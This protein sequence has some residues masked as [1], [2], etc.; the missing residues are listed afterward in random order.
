MPNRFAELRSPNTRSLPA[1][2]TRLR[3]RLPAEGADAV[4][5]LLDS[6]NVEDDEAD[7][8]AAAQPLRL[9][10]PVRPANR[11]VVR[12]AV[13][14]VA[15][16]PA[17]MPAAKPA[18]APA[19]KPAA[20][21]LA[22]PVESAPVQA[23]PA[24]AEPA[25]PL[26][27]PKSAEQAAIVQAF[28]AGDC[29]LVVNAVAG[30][31]KT[32]CILH[33]ALALRDSAPGERVLVLTYNARL[34]EE[35]RRKVRALGLSTEVHSF[36]AF[37][38]RFYSRDCHKDEGLLR[39]VDDDAA[40]LLRF[41]FNRI[42]VDE[43]QD[44]TPTFYRLVCKVMRDNQRSQP[45]PVMLLGDQHQNIFGFKYADARYLTLARDAFVG[46]VAPLP[47]RTL[48]LSTTFRLSGNMVAFANTNVMHRP[49]FN[50]P[51]AAGD[52]VFYY[53]G[54]AFAIARLLADK[55]IL[56]LSRRE[57]RPSDIFVL[58]P[59]IRAGKASTPTPY[60]VL[61]NLL[62][63]AGHPCFSSTSDDARLDE[64]VIR[65]KVVF[66]TFHSVKGL[67]RKVVVI[68]SFSKKY[69]DFFDKS[70]DYSRQRTCPNAL[71]VALTRATHALHLVGE[72]KEGDVLPFLTALK[73][74][75]YLQV[76]TVGVLQKLGAQT[77][78]GWSTASVTRLTRFLTEASITE[79][80]RFVRTQVVQE[81]LQRIS[82][83]L[84]VATPSDDVMLM[85]DVSELN[86]LAVPAFYESKSTGKMSSMQQHC[87]S[88]L[89]IGDPYH[90]TAKSKPKSM[91]D[92]LRLAAVYGFVTGG[93]VA[94]PAQIKDYDW[95]TPELSQALLGI[96]DAHL[97]GEKVAYEVAVLLN[98]E[99]LG[100]PTQVAKVSPMEV[101][102]RL[103]AVTSDF[104]WE[105]K[106]TGDI[107]VEHL[108]QLALYGWL[109]NVLPA[110]TGQPCAATHGSR[111]LRLLNFRTGEVREITS[112]P[113][114]L[115]QVARVLMEE[116]LRADPNLSDE[117]FLR[118]CQRHRKPYLRAA[119]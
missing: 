34:K 30:S 42:V 39:V 16:A 117:V 51:N 102:G 1:L 85:E 36:H 71:Y 33:A 61:E 2:L 54:D 3:T 69:F 76:L 91:A 6:L 24:A 83:P 27:Q 25:G 92:Y 60:N 62:V 17:A 78:S 26:L 98:G 113:A 35:T 14:P 104:I 45:C 5:V 114:E 59:S 95:L 32:T 108:L 119:E 23:A 43:A 81:P 86:G 13:R 37:G 11:P 19:A 70:A 68:F 46:I 49:H 40:P 80:M 88:E 53:R 112:S 96:I 105:L 58:S 55:L 63:E 111:R 20:K 15:P 47:W 94:K 64:E 4:L 74:T 52:K 28:V 41:S 115:A 10:L 99:K 57:L 56:A 93:F 50:T 8:G 89:P 38:V 87:I 12:L 97:G 75:P 18:A 106:C 84:R 79:A 67:E 118:D 31:G 116:Y 90:A 21:P 77:A 22:R 9:A 29:N 7:E 72:E 107:E 82:V 48:K 65:D 100:G 44:L 109:W 66:S 101:T 110:G 73:Q 103:D